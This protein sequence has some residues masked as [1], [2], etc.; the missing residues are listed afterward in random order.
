MY[1]QNK[2][3]HLYLKQRLYIVLVCIVLFVVLCGLVG[4]G[5][6]TATADLP[7]T[8]YHPFLALVVCGDNT[9]S[10]PQKF[11]QEAM[12]NL[13]DKISSSVV[14]NSQGMFVDVNLIEASSLQ[15]TFVSFQTQTIPDTA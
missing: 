7:P 9:L 1:S 14:P 6:N 12:Q 5:A 11:L 8:P 15:D 10:Y 2:N 4:C 3:Q 13:A